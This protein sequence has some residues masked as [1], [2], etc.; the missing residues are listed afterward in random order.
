MAFCALDHFSGGLTMPQFRGADFGQKGVPPD[1]H[2]LADY[3]YQR[4][5][6]S[7]MV[8]S[9]AKFV[10]WSLAPDAP[11]FISKGVQHRTKHDEFARLRAS[12]DRGVPVPLGLIVARD[13]ANLGRNHQVVAYG[14]EHDAAA[15]KHTVHIYDVN[16]PDQE[17]TLTSG[18]DDAGWLESSP[19]KEQ[20][21][22][23]FVQDFAPRR[24]PPDLARPLAV[25][26]ARA[27]EAKPSLRS[28]AATLEVT[29]DRVT[30]DN[31]GDPTAA[32][33]VALVLGANGQTVR[34]P[35]RKARK[36]KHGARATIGK[37][38]RVRASGDDALVVSGYL[39]GEA[40]ESELAIELRA[41]AFQQRFTRAERFGRG[42]H[43]ARSAGDAGAYVLEY[44]IATAKAV[45]KRKARRKK[46]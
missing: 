5:L 39:A 42:A 30:F 27:L 7:F 32:A 20:W 24:P 22:G 11:N 36:V 25:V 41:G 33:E 10:T 4:Q 17:I 37:S 40:G 9:A 6:D 26:V 14:Y 16:W 2:P 44:T 12:I 18:K 28:A 31:P 46:R 43:R 34:W 23:W 29:F 13:L 38:V 19:G 1:G 3:I 35:A 8:L 45:P 15:Q 21:R